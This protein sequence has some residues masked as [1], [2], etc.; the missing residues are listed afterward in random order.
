MKGGLIA[1]SIVSLVG[2][3]AYVY[4][5]RKRRAGAEPA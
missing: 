4:Y 5:D 3:I 2:F 1:V